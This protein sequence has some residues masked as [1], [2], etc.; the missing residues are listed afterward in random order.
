MAHPRYPC[1]TV[2]P[3][4]P[5]GPQ[6]RYN[7]LRDAVRYQDA[8]VGLGAPHGDA[9]ADRQEEYLLGA[10]AYV[11]EVR[12]RIHARCYPRPQPPPV[13][14]LVQQGQ[15]V[16][17]NNVQPAIRRIE[18][19]LRLMRERATVHT[20]KT[21]RMQGNITQMQGNITQMQVTLERMER[22]L[23]QVING[24]KTQESTLNQVHNQT[25]GQGNIRSYKKVRGLERDNDPDAIPGFVPIE[26]ARQI[27]EAD[28]A[29]VDV[30][31]QAYFARPI[32][33]PL[34]EK[35]RRVA[36]AIGLTGEVCGWIAGPA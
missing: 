24:Q 9:P 10:E 21:T 32:R 13:P 29:A 14:P 5:L 22:L 16:Q 15:P 8:V 34:P 23:E 12:Q 19:D 17:P 7:D 4:P 27:K 2:V 28:E 26:S 35:K 18:R 25:A 6:I 36:V 20:R 31:C 1:P 3:P 30:W 11:Q 33:A